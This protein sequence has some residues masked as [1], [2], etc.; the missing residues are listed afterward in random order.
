[1]VLLVAATRVSPAGEEGEKGEAEAGRLAAA[2]E[3][4]LSK[5]YLLATAHQP[6]G[7]PSVSL[8]H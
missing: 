4:G 6:G 7:Q 1:M 8:R 5:V 2:N 3:Q